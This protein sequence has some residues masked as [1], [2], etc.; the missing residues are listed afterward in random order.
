M[1]KTILALLIAISSIQANELPVLKA[2]QT[3]S[4]DQI[5]EIFS[6]LQKLLYCPHMFFLFESINKLKKRHICKINENMYLR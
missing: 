3:I 2:G 4:A 6:V 1:K 5:N